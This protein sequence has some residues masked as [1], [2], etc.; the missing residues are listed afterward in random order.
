[1][2]IWG[3]KGIRKRIGS[4]TFFC[5]QC[6]RDSGYTQ[7]RLSR[8]FTLYFIPLFPTKT[9]GEAVQCDSC[10]GSFNMGVLSLSREAIEAATAP[11]TCTQCGNRNSSAEA[12][13]LSCGVPRRA[14]PSPPPLPPRLPSEPRQLPPGGDAS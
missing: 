5:P 2:I 9:L 14:E 7:M 10:S 4:G 11:W 12:R 1:M 3:S 13:C 6:R 8:Y